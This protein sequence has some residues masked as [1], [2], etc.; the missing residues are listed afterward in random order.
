[1]KILRMMIW[2]MFFSLASSYGILTMLAVFNHDIIYSGSEMLEEFMIALVLGWV[3]GLGSII[4]QMERIPIFAQLFI[5][6]VF[7]T[8]CVLTAGKI[9]GWYASQGPLSVWI[10][11][12]IEVC[13]Y[14]FVWFI[15]Y[16][17]TQRDIEEINQKIKKIRGL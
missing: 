3:I 14:I 12:I 17:M 11:L 2:G 10:V 1:M 15:L 6:F 7:V 16:V 9:G 13:I 5:H 4:F 8:V